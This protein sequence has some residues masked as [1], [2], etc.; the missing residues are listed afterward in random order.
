MLDPRDL[1]LRPAQIGDLKGGDPQENA[2]ITRSLLAGEDR[3]PRRDVVLLNAAAALV[4][5]GAAA[6]LEAGI[7]RAAESIDGGAAL[8]T[9]DALIRYGRQVA[10]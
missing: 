2:R 9:L 10:A 1:G 5:G 7:V 3:G 4:A 6:D 8:N